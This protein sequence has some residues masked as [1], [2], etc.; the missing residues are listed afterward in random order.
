[1]GGSV[2]G[3]FIMY[4]HHCTHLIE[5]MSSSSIIF[6]YMILQIGIDDGKLIWNQ[7]SVYEEWS[8]MGCVTQKAPCKGNEK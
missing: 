7:E 5:N 1:M 4:M 2:K 3:S 6:H 8:K